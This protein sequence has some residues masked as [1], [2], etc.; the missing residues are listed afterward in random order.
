MSVANAARSELGAEDVFAGLEAEIE[1]LARAAKN[2]P[3][4]W[5]YTADSL[6]AAQIALLGADVDYLFDCSPS[7]GIDLTLRGHDYTQVK[8]NSAEGV[9][10][11]SESSGSVSVVTHSALRGL[12][13][14]VHGTP[15]GIGDTVA[16]NRMEPLADNNGG[17]IDRLVRWA[18]VVAAGPV[19]AELR[20][21][22]H[23]AQIG[24]ESLVAVYAGPGHFHPRSRGTHHTFRN[25]SRT[26]TRWSN[27]VAIT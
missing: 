23:H 3:E 24:G 18:A 5:A 14:A 27:A 25:P 21:R 13:K 22:G 10:V 9:Q 20:R 6:T 7:V 1:C 2:S 11:M 4:Q 16:L 8:V 12:K 15:F 17:H 26:R 19:E